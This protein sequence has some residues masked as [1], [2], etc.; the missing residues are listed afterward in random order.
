MLYRGQG[1]QFTIRGRGMKAQIE[2]NIFQTVSN[3]LNLRPS[4]G[5]VV[6]G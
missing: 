1:R 2:K 6:H 5:E 3:K 4:T